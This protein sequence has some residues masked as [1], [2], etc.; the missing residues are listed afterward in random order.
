MDEQH[1]VENAGSES[2]WDTCDCRKMLPVVLL[3][4]ILDIFVQYNMFSLP[5]PPPTK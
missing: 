3:H 1:V 5:P 2:F 4:I